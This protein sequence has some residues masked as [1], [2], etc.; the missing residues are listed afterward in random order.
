MVEKIKV[1][2]VG[3][4]NCFSGLIQGIE[5]Y[6]KNPEQKVIECKISKPS[7]RFVDSKPPDCDNSS[8]IFSISVSLLISISFTGLPALIILWKQKLGYKILP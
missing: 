8:K 2:L 6:N 5:Y 7:A 3:I 1:G 4:G